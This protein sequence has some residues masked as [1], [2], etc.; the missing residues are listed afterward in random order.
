MKVLPAKHPQAVRVP[1]RGSSTRGRVALFV[2][3]VEIG[4]RVD[5]HPQAVRVPLKGSS[6]RG[7]EAI[8]VLEVCSLP[9]P[10]R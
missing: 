1:L 7:R 6:T 3:E 8:L 9:Q 4:P 5:E 2:L 10:S